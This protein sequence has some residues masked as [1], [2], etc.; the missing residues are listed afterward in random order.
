MNPS[1]KIW[2]ISYNLL[3]TDVK[4]GKFQNRPDGTPHKVVIADESHNIK[5]WSAARTK[6]VV[7][8]MR[9][10][11]RAVLLSGT[12][13]RNTADE[14]HPQLCGIMP[15]F[16]AKFMDFRARY[17]LMKEQQLFNGK[18]VSRVVGTRNAAE[19]NCL[20]TDTVMVRR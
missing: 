6:S 14:L 8:I 9:N 18:T 4:H 16:P 7:A 19:L 5:E 12:P 3:A 17:C 13:T 2:I 11:K 10:A 1:A 20:L 15:W